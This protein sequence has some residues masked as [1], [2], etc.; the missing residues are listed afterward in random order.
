MQGLKKGERRRIFVDAE[1]AYGFYELEK[2]IEVPRDEVPGRTSLKL[3]DT[4]MIALE[5]GRDP[6]PHRIIELSGETM[7]LDGNHPLAGQDLIFEIEA[8][9][10]RDDDEEDEIEAL[11]EAASANVQAARSVPVVSEESQAATQGR[12]KS[13]MIH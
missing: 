11:A 4:V 3:G 9:D 2:V 7:M 12:S 8:T 13:Y 10:V 6:L 5:E 1:E